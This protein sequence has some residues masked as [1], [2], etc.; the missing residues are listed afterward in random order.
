MLPRTKSDRAQQPVARADK[1]RAPVVSDAQ[2]QEGRQHL[3]L[4]RRV[5]GGGAQEGRQSATIV[6]ET[7]VAN[8]NRRL[9]VAGGQPLAAT[10]AK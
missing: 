5:V 8:A 10:S 7:V 9:A 1:G 6:I 4:G 2:A 3:L